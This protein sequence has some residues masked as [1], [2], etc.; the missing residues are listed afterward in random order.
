MRCFRTRGKKGEHHPEPSD[1]PRRRANKRR[2][3]GSY[4]NDRPP[5]VGSVGRESA[6]VRLRVVG[7]TDKE[8]LLPHVHR[9]TD[10]EATIYTDEWRAYG[11]VQREHR[12]VAH[13]L[14]EWARD[15]DEDGIREVHVNTIEGLWTTLRNFLRPFRGVHK[16]YLGGY[17]AMCEFAINLK[18]ITP[19]FI[20]SLVARHSV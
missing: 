10:T 4:D 5:I 11:R 9:Y 15:D 20:C 13:G 12:T 14:K 16:K 1:P 6:E 7:H 2:G 3:H 18:R 17:V 8:T 19:A